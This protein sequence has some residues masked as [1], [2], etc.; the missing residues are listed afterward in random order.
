VP[1]KPWRDAPILTRASLLSLL[2]VIAI[3]LLGWR[4]YWLWREGPWNLPSPGKVM[5][6]ASVAQDK[7][8]AKVAPAVNTQVIISKN[9]FDPERGAGSTREA[10]ANSRAFQ[11]IRSMVLLGTVI[12]GD[13]RF[14]IVQDPGSQ[15]GGPPA[16]GQTAAPVRMKLG[17]SIEGYNLA[18]I[19]DKRVVFARGGAR[20]EVLMDYFRKIDAAPSRGPA[21]SQGVAPTGP[22]VPQVVPNLPRRRLPGQ[23]NANPSP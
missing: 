12:L 2:L 7:S 20:V 9:L 23:P 10:E 3:G 18:E 5:P 13:S 8:G 1:K 14:A 22:V 6:A 17:D 11:R 15:V 16:A 4:T 19:A 21:P